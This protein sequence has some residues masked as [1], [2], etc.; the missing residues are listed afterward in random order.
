MSLAQTEFM[1]EKYRVYT[2]ALQAME[3]KPPSLAALLETDT[4]KG[5]E[6]ILWAFNVVYT[7]SWR[8]GGEDG[9]DA[10][11]NIVPLVDMFNHGDPANVAVIQDPELDPKNVNIV[12]QTDLDMQLDTSNVNL[13]LSY[14]LTNSHRFLT[15]FGF[16]DESMPV[17]FS[18][19]VFKSPSPEMIALGCND[20]SEMVFN[21]KDGAVAN[22]VWDSYFRYRR[23]T[24]HCRHRWMVPHRSCCRKKSGSVL[25]WDREVRRT[26]TVCLFCSGNDDV[27]EPC[28]LCKDH[29]DKF[30]ER[31]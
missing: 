10:D 13:H 17:L 27:F 15:I 3:D 5:Q 9:S 1:D 16:V 28:Y 30:H 2:K 22:A 6:A 7:R 21:A 24:Y 8:V 25:E 31:T 14:G 26:A 12:L 23:H 29:Y 11:S 20:R 19:I 18:Q 4:V